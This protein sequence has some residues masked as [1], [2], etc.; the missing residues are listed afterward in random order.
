MKGQWFPLSFAQ[1]MFWFLDQLQPDTPA[2]NLP[3][4]V[5]IKGELDIQALRKAFGILLRRHDI[6]RTGFFSSEGELVMRRRQFFSLLDDARSAL[7]ERTAV[8]YR[9]SSHCMASPRRA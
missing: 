8:G 9:I 1:R 4:V 3:R 5:K 7:T 2:Y 6:L